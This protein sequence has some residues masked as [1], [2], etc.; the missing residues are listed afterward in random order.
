MLSFD[1]SALA[2]A[3][4]FLLLTVQAFERVGIRSL[5]LFLAATI[6]G[7]VSRLIHQAKQVADGRR[8][9]IRPLR[10]PVTADIAELSEAVVAMANTLETRSAYIREF[11]ANVSH[12]FK[13]PLTSIQGA[14]ELLRDHAASMDED[15]RTRFLD[16]I[17]KDSDRLARLVTRLLELARADVMQPG[18]AGLA[19]IAR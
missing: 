2:D 13:T 19:L 16:N 4:F 10:Y 15:R 18:G 9:G 5:S 1:A 14:V 7:P 11:A 6:V 8:S 12:E 3:R 17:A